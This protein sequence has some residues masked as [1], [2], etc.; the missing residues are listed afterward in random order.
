MLGKKNAVKKRRF[1]VL[2]AF[3]F[4]GFV[5]IPNGIFQIIFMKF[6]G[7]IRVNVPE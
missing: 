2:L 7:I 4:E 1:L 5:F 3:F 6:Y